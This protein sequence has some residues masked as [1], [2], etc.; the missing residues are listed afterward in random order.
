MSKDW[1]ETSPPQFGISIAQ[2]IDDLGNDVFIWDCQLC[3]EER[4]RSSWW[5]RDEDLEAHVGGAEHRDRLAR[6]NTWTGRGEG[7]GARWGFCF[8]PP[9]HGGDHAREIF[10]W[11]NRG[12]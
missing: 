11:E 6:C 9:G 10:P 2:E 4:S 1:M 12:T 3:G 5:D 8:L 7:A